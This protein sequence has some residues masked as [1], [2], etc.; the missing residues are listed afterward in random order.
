MEATEDI[1][2]RAVIGGNNPPL[3]EVLGDTHKDI[4]SE[5]D[6]MII[7]ANGTPREI[8]DDDDLGKVGE[9]VTDVMGLSK[10][11]DAKRVEEKEPYLTGGR[12][13]D[14]FFK[15]YTERL[16]RITSVFTD[17]A[18]AFQRKKA[19]DAARA[20]AEEAAALRAEEERLRQQA[21]AAKRPAT[22]AKKEDAA[23]EIAAKADEAEARASVAANDF[24]KVKTETGVTAGAKKDWT[25]DITDYENIP[26]DRLRPYFKRAEVETALKAYVKI[27][28]GASQLPGVHFKEEVK[29][30]FRR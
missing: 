20:A 8:K 15:Q 16:D 22:A 27:H 24:S 4:V 25:F 5:F 12:K 29:A 2:E 13:V 3:E 14:G 17:L 19:A 7:R 11:L 30:T 28:K 6:K 9:L 10:R 26:L 23:D 21:E 18:S 1:N